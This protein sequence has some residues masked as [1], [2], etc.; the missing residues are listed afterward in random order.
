MID[1]LKLDETIQRLLPHYANQQDIIEIYEDATFSKLIQNDREALL[2]VA[3]TLYNSVHSE[4]T[5]S[6]NKPI[7]R[8]SLPTGEVLYIAITTKENNLIYENDPFYWYNE[9][10]QIFTE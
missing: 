4:V 9:Y 8:W 1:R 7:I 2:T 3:N 6:T 5:I 10:I